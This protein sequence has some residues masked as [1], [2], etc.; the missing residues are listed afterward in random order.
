[1]SLF[2]PTPKL[3]KLLFGRA[4][5]CAYP[6]CEELLIQEHRGQISVTAEIAH[7]RAESA[8]GPRYDPAFEPVN[9]EE[10]LLLLCP[11]HH[12]WIDDYADD[13]P[14][15]EL[16]DWKREQVAQGRS[17]GLTESQAERIF[18]ALTTPQAEVEA[19]GVLSAGG[20]N[21]VAKIEN[22]KAFNP[23]NGESVERHFGVRVSNVGA[24][25]FSVDGVGVMFD[26]DGLP[27]AYLFP[28]AHRLHRPLKRLEPHANGVWLAEPDHLS[29]ITKELLRKAR[30]PIRFRAFG[31]L[32]SG[33]RVDGPWVSGLHLPIW[34]DHVTQEWVDALGRVSLMG[35][36]VDRM[37][38]S[39]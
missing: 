19:V 31:D 39:D 1:M 29:L 8:G 27:S 20:E 10:N 36:S 21:I 23:I 26:L 14:V 22:V 35:W 32:G 18:K 15:E 7:I 17:V 34:E 11:K 30:V 25:G 9:K 38:P 28:A 2:K 37:C 5:H 24:I 13:Y 12:G 33:T 16:L 3:C 4:S 6:E